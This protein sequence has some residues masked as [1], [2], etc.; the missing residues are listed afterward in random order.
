MIDTTR[1]SRLLAALAAEALA[2]PLARKLLVC[3][4][5]G[6]GLELLRSLAAAGRPWIGFTATT[7]MRLALELVSAG[8]ADPELLDEFDEQALID[9]AIDDVLREGRAPRYAVFAE[10]VG[11]RRA[12]ARAVQ[13]LRLAG[14][15]PRLVQRAL[16]DTSKREALAAIL[17]RYDSLRIERGRADAADVFA[18]A[19]ARVDEGAVL[20]DA[21]LL[22]VP[23]HN[24]RGVSGGLLRCLVD[25]GA[26]LLDEDTPVGTAPA[27]RLGGSAAVAPADPHAYLRM[28]ADAPGTATRLSF[29]AATSIQAELRE[30]L[31]RI[32]GAGA[33]W[34][35]AEIVATDP[36]TYAVALDG[37]ARRLGVPVGYAMGL[38]VARTRPGRVVSTYLRWI[39]DDF[40]ED[41]IRGLIER[42]EIMPRGD[43]V[44]AGPTLARRLRRLRIGRGRA[45]Y[46]ETIDAALRSIARTRTEDDDRSGTE[47]VEARARE[48]VQL[49]ALRDLLAPIL[50]A[51]PELS[52]ALPPEERRT[53]PA[54][55]ARGVRAALKLTSVHADVDRAARDRLLERLERIE[56][57]LTREVPLRAA[58]A[59]LE[60]KLDDR[61]PAPE[62]G[63]RAPW[64]SSG[65]RLHFTDL[66]GAGVSGRHLTFVVGLDASRFPDAPL[67]DT[68]LS[69]ADRRALGRHEEVPSL[70]T[71]TER[72]DERRYALAALLART[73]GPV[74]LSYAAWSAA[75]GRALAPSAE[76][77]QAYRLRTGRAGADYE[78]LKAA[79]VPYVSAVPR[80]AQLDGADAW[81]GGLDDGGV[82]R[83][84]DDVVREAYPSLGRGI[85]AAT[86]RSGDVPSAHHGVITPRPIFDPRGR[87]VPMSAS[88]LQSLGECP[89][90]YLVLHVLGV[91]PPED[92]EAD[93]ARWLSPLERGA[94]LHEVFETTLSTARDRGL[95]RDADAVATLAAEVLEVVIDRLRREQPPPGE[96]VYE[97]ERKALRTDVRAFVRMVAEDGRSWVA[98]EEAFGED[99]PVSLGL[100]GGPLRVR[101]KIDRVD[102]IADDAL[103]VVDYKTGSTYPFRAESGVWAG[104]RRLQHAFYTAGAEAL[105]GG[106]VQAVEYHFPGIRGRNERVVYSRSQLDGGVRLIDHLLDL[107][108]RGW[109]VPTEDASSDCKYCDVRHVCRVRQR[110][111][112]RIES[113]PADWSARLYETDAEVLRALRTLREWQ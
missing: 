14:A 93:P 45:R 55:L 106:T 103:V 29:F 26:V 70:P 111:G 38:P 102:R 25:R 33:R 101:G 12:L 11:L 10:G 62:A 16:A 44:P 64:V 22:I 68:L 90:R 9:E 41:V 60:E 75:D 54:A 107:A 109:F 84:G 56:A 30:V 61:V 108:A 73:R 40:R 7:P 57:T 52:S 13:A 86:A 79:L 31:R 82:L 105:H 85:A 5:H 39:E 81:L 4:R 71:S 8:A 17:G 92:P 77:L 23:G 76:L 32:I 47:R 100:P 94:A 15:S 97:A 58:L 42:S 50:R 53:T 110:R 67:H 91:R 74:T 65:G 48:R 19:T 6:E 63:G 37:L 35:E 24:L 69:D 99:A 89:H 96:A 72:I 18:R 3:R 46:L 59:M 20:P 95:E 27:A 66:D 98:L 112:D 21:R 83:R 1:H 2:Y 34:D 80:G 51:T 43:G 78:D 28:V 113:P 88:R 36:A 49:Q 87:D 104:G